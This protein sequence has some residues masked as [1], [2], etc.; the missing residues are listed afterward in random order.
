MSRRLGPGTLVFILLSMG[1]RPAVAHGF[2]CA[3][4]QRLCVGPHFCLLRGLMECVVNEAFPRGAQREENQA[5]AAVSG[6]TD[7]D[8][9][10]RYTSALDSF[11]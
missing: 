3:E 1:C 4:V 2:N 11:F 9:G 8:P 5:D 6:T 10:E 7:G